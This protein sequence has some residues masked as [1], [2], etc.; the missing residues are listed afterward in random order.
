MY[1]FTSITVKIHKLWDT[2]KF[3]MCF[4]YLSILINPMSNQVDIKYKSWSKTEIIYLQCTM[5][6]TRNRQNCRK[7]CFFRVVLTKLF[8]QKIFKVLLCKGIG[9]A[10]LKTTG[11]EGWQVIRPLRLKNIWKRFIEGRIGYKWCRDNSV[12]KSP[13]L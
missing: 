5:F 9:I 10:Y 8:N 11:T 12:V 1:I 6:T 2:T 3:K 13:V 7:I 4:N